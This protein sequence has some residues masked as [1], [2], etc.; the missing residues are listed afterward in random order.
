VARE[1]WKRAGVS[2]RSPLRTLVHLL[3]QG[4]GGSCAFAHVD[5]DTV[6]SD[7]YCE[8]VLRLLHVDGSIAVDNVSWSCFGAAPAGDDSDAGAARASS[9][10]MGPEDRV[11]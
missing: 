10:R 3:A 4:Q 5:A 6:N 2:E 8:R 1:F 9:S 11:D 7:G